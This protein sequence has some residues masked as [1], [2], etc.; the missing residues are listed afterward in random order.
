[1]FQNYFHQSPS[2]PSPQSLSH[3]RFPFSGIHLSDGYA[4]THTHTHNLNFG[5]SEGSV[6]HPDTFTQLYVREFNSICN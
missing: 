6:S 1:M 2:L 5:Y 3:A 4:H